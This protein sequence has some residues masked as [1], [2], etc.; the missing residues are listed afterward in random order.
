MTAIKYSKP[1]C[2]RNQLSERVHLHLLHHP[3]AMCFHGA[4]GCSQLISDLLVDLSADD[5]TEDLSLTRCQGRDEPVKAIELASLMKC[6]LVSRH[7]ALDRV[8]QLF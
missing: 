6:G 4:L 5:Q 8:D 1:L 7:R 2:V 3:V